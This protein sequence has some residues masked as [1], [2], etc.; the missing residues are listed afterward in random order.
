MISIKFGFD[1]Q[2]RYLRFFHLQENNFF[3]QKLVNFFNL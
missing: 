3:L 2:G 1:K